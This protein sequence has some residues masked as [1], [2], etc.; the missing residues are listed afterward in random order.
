ME[1]DDLELLNKLRRRGGESRLTP[2]EAQEEA[3]LGLVEVAKYGPKHL[4]VTLCW[5]EWRAVLRV[6]L[7]QLEVNE[8]AVEERGEKRKEKKK[9]CVSKRARE[10]RRHNSKDAPPRHLQLEFLP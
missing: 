1:V 4:D 6:A 5:R 10:A 8:T 3:Q 9:V 7:Q 2:H